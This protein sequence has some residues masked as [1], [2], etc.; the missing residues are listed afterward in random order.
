[1]NQIK[2]TFRDCQR[3]LAVAEADIEAKLAEA[4][5]DGKSSEAVWQM[6]QALMEQHDIWSLEEAYWQAEQALLDWAK[7]KVKNDPKTK[8]RYLS[9]PE[10]EK[11]WQTSNKKIRASLIQL[12]LLLEE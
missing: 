6:E 5:P 4:F 11:V 2:R 7:E 12:C 1:M 8:A 9:H 3:Q 10:V